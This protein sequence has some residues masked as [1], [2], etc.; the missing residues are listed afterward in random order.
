MSPLLTTDSNHTTTKNN[1]PPAIRIWLYSGMVLILLMFIVGSITRLTGSGLSITE[2]K[3]I[4]GILPPLSQEEW[5]Q[6]FEKYKQIPQFQKVNYWMTVE[7]FKTIY[8]WEYIHRLLGRIIGLVFLLPFLYFLS[9]KQI[10]G[11]LLKQV[12]FV[13]FLG[14]LQGFI[15]WYM[16]KSGLSKLTSVSH[17]RLAIHL[18]TAGITLTYLYYI[19]LSHS[20]KPAIPP[21]SQ[22]SL[23]TLLL[24]LIVLVPIQIIYG[25][26]TAGLKAGTMYNTFPLMNGKLLPVESAFSL[27]P[28]WLNFF[29]NPTLVQFIH[30]TGGWLILLTSLPLLAKPKG[31]PFLTIPILTILQFLLGI[32]TLLFQVPVVLGVL[33]Q[34]TGILL[35]LEVFRSYYF[36]RRKD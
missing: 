36:F 23:H 19:I 12:L 2:W 15:G 1:L 3:P 22:K 24:I 26:F 20:S 10:K 35:W 5:I 14:L 32:F 34:L 17:Y 7:D 30:R 33:H 13:F 4:T 6:E 21:F 16:V 27:T 8:W 18:L 28:F 29:E 25:A 9:L 31:N 11:K